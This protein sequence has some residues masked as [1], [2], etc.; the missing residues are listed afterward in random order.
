MWSLTDRLV[1]KKSLVCSFLFSKKL[2]QYPLAV[3]STIYRGSQVNSNI[4][5]FDETRTT[6]TAASYL[7]YTWFELSNA[8]KIPRPRSYHSAPVGYQT[9][10]LWHMRPVK[11]DNISCFLHIW[12]MYWQPLMIF[13]L[14]LIFTCD[15][16]I[17]IRKIWE[18]EQ[19]ITR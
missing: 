18:K 5:R 1:I 9:R 10:Y 16:L 2:R 15:T 6:L 14:E 4:D 3:L 12:H 13:K 19:K 8:N 11:R 17:P 7:F